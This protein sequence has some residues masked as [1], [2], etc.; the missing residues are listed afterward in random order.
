M[1]CRAVIPVPPFDAMPV[2]HD[3]VTQV[4]ASQEA[5]ARIA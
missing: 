3:E 5:G 1:R 4:F 2:Q